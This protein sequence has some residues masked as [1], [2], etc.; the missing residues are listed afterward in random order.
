MEQRR[1]RLGDILD[2]YCPRER[3][4]TN[5]AVVAMVEETVK[6]TRCT[7]CDAEHPYKGGQTPRRRKK[8]GPSALY[9]E[10]LAGKAD[11]DVPPGM[12]IPEVVASVDSPDESEL[13]DGEVNGNVMAAGESRPPA[14]VSRPAPVVRR[15]PARAVAPPG[16]DENRDQTN[17]ENLDEDGDEREPDAEDGPV[18]RQLI[19][20]TLPRIEG[21][22]EERRPTDFTIRQAGGRGNNVGNQF[23]GGGGGAIGCDLAVAR[24]VAVPD[25]VATQ[26]IE[27]TAIGL[28]AV[29]GLPV[30]APV[31]GR[32]RGMVKARVAD[33]VAA[34]DRPN[35]HGRAAAAGSVPGSPS[36]LSSVFSS[37]FSS[38]FSSGAVFE[39]PPTCREG[40]CRAFTSRRSRFFCC[41]AVATGLRHSTFPP[42][43]F[44]LAGRGE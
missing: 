22:K 32:A 17:V 10:V 25:R 24:R 14:I 40:S 41:P 15:E 9:K 20:A 6:Q 31:K 36:S 8:D 3:R 26:G 13:E 37:F 19:R 1:L 16:P 43:A 2:D 5:H 42:S 27:A 18:H 21:H 28:R 30:R 39:C 44:G 7:T 12:D 23:R 34:S 35:S 38:F 4:L 33:R 11:T 29:P